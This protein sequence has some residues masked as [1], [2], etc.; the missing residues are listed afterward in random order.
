MKKATPENTFLVTGYMGAG[1]T[2]DDYFKGACIAKDKGS[3]MDLMT[4]RVP[5][6]NPTGANS[7]AEINQIA[8]MLNKAMT[9]EIPVP[10][11]EGYSVAR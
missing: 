5:M 7:L 3:A 8:G 1:R 10:R 2:K 6:L 4:E 11:Q 9:G